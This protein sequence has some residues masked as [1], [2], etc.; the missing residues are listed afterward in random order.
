MKLSISLPETKTHVWCEMM[1]RLITLGVATEQELQIMVGR[2]SFAQTCVFG[3]MGR[4]MP[5]PFYGKLKARTYHPILEERELNALRWWAVALKALLPRTIRPYQQYPDLIIYTDAATSTQIICALVIGV[6]SCKSAPAVNE[7]ITMTT[8]QRWKTLFNKTNYI[9]GLEMLAILA[10]VID[11]MADIDGKAIVF[12]I[13]NDNSVKSLV[14]NQSDTR[15]IQTMTLLN[16]HMLALRGVRS[17]FEWVGSNLNPADLPTR[18]KTLPFLTRKQYQPRN[19]N[20]ARRR[21]QEGL[22]LPESG[23]PIPTPRGVPCFSC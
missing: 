23:K 17:W 20:R 15:V 9:Y 5:P 18:R 19:L 3:K 8:G 10:L 6:E 11:P 13:D 21:I 22:T 14:K 4:A 1:G 7:C 16:W 2:L 12:Y